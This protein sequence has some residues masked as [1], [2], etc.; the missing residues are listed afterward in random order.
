MVQE[1]KIFLLV[2]SIIFTSKFVLEFIIK[3]FQDEPDP[4][5]ITKYDTIFIYLAISY[6]VTFLII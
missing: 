3:F 6:I 4:I 2:L 1:I 5:N